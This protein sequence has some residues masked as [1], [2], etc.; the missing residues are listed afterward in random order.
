MKIVE[1]CH[2]CE[3]GK[4]K[5]QIAKGISHNKKKIFVP[6]ISALWGSWERYMQ[7]F[8][9]RRGESRFFTQTKFEVSVGELQRA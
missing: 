2:S 3:R 4:E 7:M 9:T 5:D 8:T 6:K 1:R